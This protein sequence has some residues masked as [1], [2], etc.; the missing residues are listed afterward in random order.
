MF[1]M[2]QVKG[3]VQNRDRNGGKFSLVDPGQKWG[4][5]EGAFVHVYQ[6]MLMIK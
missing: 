1:M 2:P 6:L 3:Y 5:V 4:G